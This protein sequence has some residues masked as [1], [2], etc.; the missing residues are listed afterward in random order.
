MRKSLKNIDVAIL[1]STSEKKKKHTEKALDTKF[2]QTTLSTTKNN[3]P[4]SI[5]RNLPF[6]AF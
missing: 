3:V 1:I 6:S 4:K 5:Q 2:Q